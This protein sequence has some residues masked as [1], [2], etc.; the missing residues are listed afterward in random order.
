M[1]DLK[2]T[3]LL[4]IHTKKWPIVSVETFLTKNRISDN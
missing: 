4:Q 1:E 3:L 2:M